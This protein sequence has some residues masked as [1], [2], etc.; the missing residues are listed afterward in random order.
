MAT[1]A[2]SSGQPL[3]WEDGRGEAWHGPCSAPGSMLD[4]A[5]SVAT[6]V[7]DHP[8]CAVVFQK[9]K[10]DFCCRGELRLER[11]SSDRGVD[12]KALVAELTAAIERRG[13]APAAD[14]RALPTEKL[15]AHI[16]EKHHEYLKDALPFVR[17]LAIKVSRV[18]GAH[19]PLL[20]DLEEAV[21]ELADTLLAHLDDEEHALFPRLVGAAPDA[22]TRTQLDAMLTEHLAVSGL[23]DRI[24]AATEDFTLPEWACNSYRA[25]FAELENMDSD[26]RAHVHLENHVLRPRFAAA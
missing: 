9:H 20:V 12:A 16:V 1:P 8:E 6:I 18:H 5:Q 14:P 23:L 15:L 26:I 17:T 19:N 2:S 25:L 10:I 24:L 11:A 4:P 7:L 3:S 13:A 21:V 22:E